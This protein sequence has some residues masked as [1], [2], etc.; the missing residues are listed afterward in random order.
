MD[1]AVRSNYFNPYW[2]DTDT[3]IDSVHL[4]YSDSI[5][6]S[7]ST[8]SVYN[9]GIQYG[10]HLDPL[11]IESKWLIDHIENSFYVW[12]TSKLANGLDFDEFK[13]LILP[14]RYRNEALDLTSSKYRELY[15]DIIQ[16]DSSIDLESIVNK[17]NTYS[18]KMSCIEKTGPHIG[19]FAFYDLMHFNTLGCDRHS[20][21]MCRVLNACGVPAALDFTP[22]WKN[23][24]RGHFWVSVRDKTGNYHPFTPMWQPLHDSIYFS[25]TSKVFR[26][27]YTKQSNPATLNKDGEEIPSAFSNPRIL[28]VTELYHKVTNLTIP[29]NQ[30]GNRR[31][32]GYLSIFSPDG[33]KPIGWGKYVNKNSALFFE[34]VPVST[35]YASGLQVDGQITP[36]THPFYVQEDGQIVYIVPDSTKRIDIHVKRKFHEKGHLIEMMEKMIGTKVL[37]S[38]TI[39]FSDFDTLHILTRQDLSAMSTKSIPMKLKKAYRYIRLIPE[40]ENELNLTGL[41]I[42]AKSSQDF[43]SK[44][45]K[46]KPLTNDNRYDELQNDN[47]DTFTTLKVL[48][49]DLMLPMLIDAIEITPRNSNNGIVPGDTYELLYFDKHWISAGITLASTNSLTFKNIPANTLY[50]LRNLDRGREEQAFLYNGERQI[51]IN[52]DNYINNSW[53]PFGECMKELY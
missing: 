20:E 38:T 44:S 52:E 13:E 51:F 45:I 17:L 49:I 37:A 27:T 46:Y 35:I 11:T 53:V 47:P 23:R 5:A 34:K 36:N 29:V 42:F 16:A 25:E 21:W 50:W 28:D 33:W 7:L 39:D 3:K 22:S 14:Y 30:T 8:G 6:T 2:G 43:E 1:S 12:N 40:G 48:E 4:I 10:N 19:N 41:K 32:L 9:S 18:T 31:E 26:L 15:W 24:N